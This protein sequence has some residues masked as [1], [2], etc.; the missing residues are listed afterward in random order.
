M[1]YILI[2]LILVLISGCA[3]EYYPKG[4]YGDRTKYIYSMKGLVECSRCK[5]GTLIYKLDKKGNIICSN[6]YE[7]IRK[8]K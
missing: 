5:K 1:R 3:N 2:L 7:K 4:D 6:C 8:D